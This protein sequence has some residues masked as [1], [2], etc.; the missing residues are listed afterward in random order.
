MEGWGRCHGG[1]GRERS[2]YIGTIGSHVSNAEGL[3]PIGECF[4][5][6]RPRRIRPN[7]DENDI[8]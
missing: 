5:P 1:K 3:T 4:F 7:E 8:S 2:K 6:F